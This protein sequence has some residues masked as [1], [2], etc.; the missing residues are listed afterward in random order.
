MTT[1][2]DKPSFRELHQPGNPFILANAWDIGSA[3]LLAGMGAKALATTSAG[4]AFTLGLADMGNVSRDDAIA[5]AGELAEA[6]P[7]PLSGD[8]E[9]GYGHDTES[10]AETIRAAAAAGLAGCS[11]EDTALPALEAY[12]FQ[13][14]VERIE[15]A[16]DACR[17]LE[18]DFVLTAR[19][20]GYM[21][22]TYDIEESIR[23][24]QAFE[25]AGADVLYAPW[26]PDLDAVGQI[27]KSVNAPVNVVC[28]S[29]FSRYSLA[30]FASAGV[31]RISLGGSLAN[32]AKKAAYDAAFAMLET[33]DFSAMGN[34]DKQNLI[35]PL[36][37][38][39][40]A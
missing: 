28:E 9:N 12:P 6:T 26:L 7:L 3:R 4:H 33:G 21:N 31:A 18:G 39:G 10:V 35:D 37:E 8:L 25:A 2:Q 1:S 23:R 16:V 40:G 22:G 24:L 11:I 27:C 20:D 30:D 13:K 5:H 34:V 32:V 19:A 14:A 38:K 17:S 36:L 29:T 15:A